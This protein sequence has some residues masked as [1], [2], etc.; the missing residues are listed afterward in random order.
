[1]DFSVVVPTYN[2][3]RDLLRTLAAYERQE[4]ADLEFEV[5]AVDDGSGDG[6]AAALADLR[7]RRFSLRFETQDNA[8]PA[9]ARN[10]A[11][12]M[13]RGD[14]VLFTGDDIEPAP[15]LL[16]RHLETHRSHGDPALAVLGLTTW[17]EDGPL[18]ATMRHIDGP[19]AQQFSY[20]YFE[21]GAEY[22]FRHLY[23]SNVS[24]TRRFLELEAG[25]FATVFPAA[26]F[27]DAEVGHRLA[28]HGLRI[29]Y[30]RD[31][32]AFHHHP[33]D[34]AGFYRRQE[35]CGRM[36]ALLFQ[37]NPELKKWLAVREVEWRRLALLGMDPQD[38]PPLQR[39]ADELDSW[40]RRAIRLATF[41]DP[42]DPPGIDGFLSPLFRL[43]YLD[44]L[45]AALLPE[46]AARRVLASFFAESI[47]D[48]AGSLEHHIAAAGVPG[49]VADL[50]A[51]T[52]VPPFPGIPPGP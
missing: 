8:G 46:P 3:R 24:L 9:K 28:Y 35:R 18:T 12:E 30:R 16:R 36:A 20:H 42:I 1:M 45:C 34:A 23:T 41:Y 17:P 15:D 39:L 47:P 2:R 38:V 49:P 29:L 44:G 22:D 11:L 7:P 32:T 27:E 40:I 13:A 26:A 37:R 4:P 50:A 25:P 14:L 33:Y 6:T 31:A 10:R 43:G 5:V 19:G 21:D 51:L 52:S 48:A